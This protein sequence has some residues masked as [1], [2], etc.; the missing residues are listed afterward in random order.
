MKRVYKLFFF[1]H[2]YFRL[3]KFSVLLLILLQVFSSSPPSHPAILFLFPLP[4]QPLY[5][6]VRPLP[7]QDAAVVA[8][9]EQEVVVVGEALPQKVVER[10]TVVHRADQTGHTLAAMHKTDVYFECI[11]KVSF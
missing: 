11:Q 10:G 1:S 5:P 4:F 8:A 2:V 3:E 7:G 9:A 6:L